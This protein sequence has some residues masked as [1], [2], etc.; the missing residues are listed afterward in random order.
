MF[1][2]SY[3]FL[4][5]IYQ[6]IM[7]DLYQHKFKFSNLETFGSEKFCQIGWQV[8]F[9]GSFQARN[10]SQYR[11]FQFSASPKLGEILFFTVFLKVFMFFPS[12]DKKM[13]GQ[14]SS[15]SSTYDLCCGICHFTEKFLD[16]CFGQ[17]CSSS[18]LHV[19]VKGLHQS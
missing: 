19:S 12:K 16:E 8:Y 5:Q 11:C 7:H 6:N 13:G 9:E 3:F 1:L 2:N 10:K 14:H 18:N 4:Y 15:T 17:S